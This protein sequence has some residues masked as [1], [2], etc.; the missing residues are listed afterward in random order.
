MKVEDK[1]RMEPDLGNGRPSGAAW[2]LI[3]GVKRDAGCSSV[4]LAIVSH[5][6]SPRSIHQSHVQIYCFHASIPTLQ[7][8]PRADST[9]SNPLSPATQ[10]DITGILQRE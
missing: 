2:I 10:S 4:D 1:T 7:L 3:G 8:F 5:T 6:R 9:V